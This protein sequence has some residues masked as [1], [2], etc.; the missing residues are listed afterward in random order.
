[1]GGASLDGELSGGIV[2]AAG[3]GVADESG[4]GNTG[5]RGD[6]LQELT[7]KI[8]GLD[9]IR[10]Q[11]A[12]QA[13]FGAEEIRGLKAFVN[14]RKAQKALNRQSSAD[15]KH[16]RKSDL[17]DDHGIAEF[18]FCEADGPDTGVFESAVQVHAAG[19]KDGGE[20]E[21]DSD[22]CCE[23]DCKSQHSVTHLNAVPAGDPFCP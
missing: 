12:G 11:T 23:R 19:M 18:G 6:G 8:A 22:E 14:V 10:I 4:R 13:D 1:M 17:C 2:H 9:G 16:Q 20:A 15:E 3:R 7:I 21:Q 5:K